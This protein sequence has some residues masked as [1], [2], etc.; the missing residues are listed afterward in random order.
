LAGWMAFRAGGSAMGSGAFHGFRDRGGLEKGDFAEGKQ[1]LDGLQVPLPL[2]AVQVE[3][4]DVVGQVVEGC[5]QD[6]VGELGNLFPG[7]RG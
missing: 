7:L 2:L 3:V 6:A 4:A 5:P 1:A